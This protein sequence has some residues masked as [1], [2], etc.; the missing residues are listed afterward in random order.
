MVAA[1]VLFACGPVGGPSRVVDDGGLA[2][3]C[4]S[5]VVLPMCTMAAATCDGP[6]P[7]QTRCKAWCAGQ[8]FYDDGP[9]LCDPLSHGSYCQQ[10]TV[11]ARCTAR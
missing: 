11:E 4:A 6:Y 9:P 1:V 5:C 10:V 8:D 3:E 2:T 7:C